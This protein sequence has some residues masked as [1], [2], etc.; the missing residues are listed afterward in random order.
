MCAACGLRL[1]R[2]VT[3]ELVQQRLSD[4]AARHDLTVEQLV[5]LSERPDGEAAVDQIVLPDV[6]A[7]YL[8]AQRNIKPQG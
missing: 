7:E 1:Q 4:L 8:R 2:T 3:T 6:I 5:Q